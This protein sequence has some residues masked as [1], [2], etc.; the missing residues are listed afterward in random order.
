MFIINGY[1]VSTLSDPLA[2]APSK[3]ISNASDVT[4]ET[5]LAGL[6]SNYSKIHGLSCRYTIRQKTTKSGEELLKDSIRGPARYQRV[7]WKAQPH[8]NLIL[9]QIEL[10]DEATDE[11]V[12]G[13][14]VTFDGSKGSELAERPDGARAASVRTNVPGVEGSV[15]ALPTLSGV[16]VFGFGLPLHR[17]LSGA[18][19]LALADQSVTDGSYRIIATDCKKTSGSKCDVTVDVDV[20]SGFVIRQVEIAETG[21][22]KGFR[23]KFVADA[24]DHHHTH[25]NEIVSFPSKAGFE[26]WHPRITS[27]PMGFG[28]IELEE[29]TLTAVQ[30]KEEFYQDFTPGTVVH[31]VDTGKS[32]IAGDRDDQLVTAR[33]DQAVEEL[34]KASRT[35]SKDRASAPSYSYAPTIVAGTIALLAFAAFLL[36]RRR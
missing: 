30:P 19:S 4:T 21:N 27:E 3:S 28:T 1:C 16:H 17:V 9:Y 5:I 26:F 35:T 32:F 20:A 13:R 29:L 33:A 7:Q 24:I 6:E 25:E 22:R 18:E 11:V 2:S 15:A 31:N 36:L 14:R 34:R 10:R 12:D 8:E 23:S